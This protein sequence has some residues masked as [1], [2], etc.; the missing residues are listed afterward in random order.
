MLKMRTKSEKKTKTSTQ[1]KRRSSKTFEAHLKGKPRSVRTDVKQES[2]QK[3]SSQK[4]SSQKESSQKESSKD[5]SHK[6][7]QH[8]ELS[9]KEQKDQMIR[10]LFQK[11]SDS[12]PEHK[13]VPRTK[14]LKKIEMDSAEKVHEVASTFEEESKLTSQDQSKVTGA[15]DQSTSSLKLDGLVHVEMPYSE[16]QAVRSMATSYK[17]T[18]GYMADLT[19]IGVND[20]SSS[21]V[22][23]D[24]HETL[25]KQNVSLFSIKEASSSEP[26]KKEISTLSTSFKNQN[27]ATKKG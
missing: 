16:P 1:T 27:T 3:E 8:K 11:E 18:S 10:E 2:P 21:S 17:M 13:A 22:K 9:H 24:L 26:T 6:D 5:H 20:S 19:A 23:R 12:P 15:L 25:Y 7:H 14:S 4:E